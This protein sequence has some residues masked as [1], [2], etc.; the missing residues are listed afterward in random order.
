MLM[1]N[2][3][4]TIALC[5]MISMAAASE[6]RAQL[7]KWADHGFININGGT[8]T[9]S[10]EF[11]ESSAPTI[12]GE[13]ASIA[14]SHAIDSGALFDVSG[15]ARVWGNLGIGV[16]YS[17]FST[18][19]SPTVSAQ[20]PNPVFFS[21]ARS[22]TAAA[23]SLE[24][25]ESVVHLQVLCMVPASRK[26]DVAIY[27][28]PS[29][30]NVS[31]DLISGD[32]T[33]SLVEGAAPFSTVTLTSVPIVRQKKSATGFNVGAD[34]S[35]LFTRQLGAGI[36]F[37]YSAASVDLPAAGGGQVSVDAGGV[38]IGVGARVRF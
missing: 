23:G 15:G 7:L 8:Q 30:F 35:F 20:I 33:S 19:E 4:L 18:N 28:G 6:S 25:S 17:S 14:T 26:V 36:F 13:A 37:R 16:G 27:G 2:M 38:Q 5:M 3:R 31:Q 11:T 21:R 9:T 29:F 32:I 34:V 12:Y 22:I 10:H 24:H 1:Q